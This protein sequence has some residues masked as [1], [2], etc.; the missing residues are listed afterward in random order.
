MLKYIRLHTK[1]DP[2]GARALGALFFFMVLDIAFY[3]VNIVKIF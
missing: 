1:R 3:I 2:T